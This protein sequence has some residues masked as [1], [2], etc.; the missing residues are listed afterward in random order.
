MTNKTH[1]PKQ[2]HGYSLQFTECLSVLLDAGLDEF[3]SVEVLDDVAMSSEG[4]T[5]LIQMKAGTGAN[6]VSDGAVELWKTV[7]NWIDQINNK[8]I[9]PTHTTFTLYVGAPHKGNICSAMSAA[10]YPVEI[11]AVVQKIKSKFLTATTNKLK[12]GLGK[13][14]QQEI[15][16]VLDQQN[17]GKLEWIISRF[18]YRHGS[19]ESYVDLESK[20]SKMAVQD[21]LLEL[22]M[23]RMAGW[24][25]RQID[26]AI[27]NGK[28]AIISVKDFRKELVSYHVKLINQPFLERFA[29]EVPEA[30][31]EEHKSRIYYRQLT[32]IEADDNEL[33]EAVGNYLS[34]CA[35]AVRYCRDG[36]INTASLE[37][38]AADL[39]TLWKQLKTKWELQGSTKGDVHFGKSLLNDCSLQKTKMQGADV[40]TSF[41][42]GSFHGLADELKIGWHPNYLQILVGT[43]DA[44]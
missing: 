21:S 15:E 39:R 6:P 32:L 26:K 11:N 7:R 43:E 30:Q 40:S 16:V 5:N 41:M 38:Y 4:K 14:V 44:L 19:A 33:M 9:D 18:D 1:V 3:V 28:D 17:L 22:M 24:V 8:E 34:A 29:F 36:T 37:E 12:R 23:D 2:L 27:E 10:K 31:Y 20:F 13:E 25:K 42:C 35:H